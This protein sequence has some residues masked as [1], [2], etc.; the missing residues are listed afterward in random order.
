MKLLKNVSVKRTGGFYRDPPAARK[1]TR[2]KDK[3]LQGRGEGRGGG[4]KPKNN[5]K[6]QSVYRSNYPV[7]LCRANDELLEE[8]PNATSLVLPSQRL[9]TSDAPSPT[10][11]LFFLIDNWEFTRCPCCFSLPFPF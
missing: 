9:L 3:K 2:E 7:S 1:R 11:A 4:K 6:S 10:A 8:T 5:N